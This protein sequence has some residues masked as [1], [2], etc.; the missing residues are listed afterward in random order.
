MTLPASGAISLSQVN[1]E[2]GKASNALI[3]LNDTAVRALAGV[4]SGPIGINNLYGKSALTLIG[5]FNVELVRSP[6]S[7]YDIYSQQPN[8]LFNY[9]DLSMGTLLGFTTWQFMV[10]KYEPASLNP[11]TIQLY[12]PNRATPYGGLTN[13]SIKAIE[14][15]GVIYPI[16]APLVNLNILGSYVCSW[17]ATVSDAI[18]STGASTIKIYG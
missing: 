15:L 10:T 5:T 6:T 2:L 11:D 12:L 13:D 18:G 17:G 1:T 7:G 16:K 9:V 8:Q 3:A 14:Y 4:P